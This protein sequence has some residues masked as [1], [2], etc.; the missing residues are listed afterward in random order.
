MVKEGLIAAVVCIHTATATEYS[1]RQLQVALLA[2]TSA[3]KIH[4]IQ[5]IVIN[6]GVKLPYFG[7]VTLTTLTLTK[8][9]RSSMVST[10]SVMARYSRTF[11]Q[12]RMI[13][14]TSDS[15]KA[16]SNADVP[17]RIPVEQANRLRI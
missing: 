4:M 5:A 14:L 10:T 8:V 15:S 2:L 12:M 3:I 6:N 9:T 7:R 1:R 13:F 11:L 17:W 16:S